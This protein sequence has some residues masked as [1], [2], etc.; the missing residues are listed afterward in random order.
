M[1][2]GDFK[3]AEFFDDFGDTTRADALDIHGGDGGFEGSVAAGAFFKKRRTKYLGAVTD[4]GD[5]EVEVAKCGVETTGLEAVGVAV[6]LGAALMGSNA[7]VLLAFDEHGCVHEG[8]RDGNEAVVE[9]VGKKD[10]DELITE[11]ILFL[12]LFVHGSIL[13]C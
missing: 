12:V 11:V 13:F 6:A 2:G 7:E 5:S 4:L 1:A 9:A 8:L 10:V 3:T